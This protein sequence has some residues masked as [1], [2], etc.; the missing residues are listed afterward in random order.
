VY[1]STAWPFGDTAEASDVPDKLRQWGHIFA[2]TYRALNNG[3]HQGHTG[4]LADLITNT[5]AFVRKITEK[6]P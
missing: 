6:L 4:E 5:R 3:A 2:D 1:S